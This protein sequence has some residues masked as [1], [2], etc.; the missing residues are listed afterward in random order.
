MTSPVETVTAFFSGA[1]QPGALARAIR[2]YFTPE[3]VWE[4]IGLS[5]TVGADKAVELLAGFGSPPEAFAMRVEMLAIAGDGDTVLTE[6]ID[7][8]AGANGKTAA[9]RVMGAFEVKQGR[10][11][12]WRDYFDTAG[13]AAGSQAAA[14]S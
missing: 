4:N 1:E 9:F 6:R 8:I 12:A 10:I 5:K 14:N 3:T 7:H 13:L 2:E 11:T